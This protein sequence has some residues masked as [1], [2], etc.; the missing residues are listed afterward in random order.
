MNNNY[1]LSVDMC[2][3]MFYNCIIRYLG[4]VVLGGIYNGRK[5]R[6]Q[7]KNIKNGRKNGK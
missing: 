1:D 7:E 6:V 4:C 2:E 3:H 5:R